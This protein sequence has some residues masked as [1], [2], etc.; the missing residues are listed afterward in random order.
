MDTKLGRDIWRRL[1]ILYYTVEMGPAAE[2]AITAI[3][4][5]VLL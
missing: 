1:W 4:D 5:E 2:A 3:K